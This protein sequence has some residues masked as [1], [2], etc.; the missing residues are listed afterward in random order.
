M[1]VK[2]NYKGHDRGAQAVLLDELAIALADDGFSSMPTDMSSKDGEKADV[3][4]GLLIAGLAVQGTGALI[5]A[6]T[7]YFNRR[8]SYTVT[9]K[10]GNATFTAG[11]LSQKEM[12]KMLTESNSSDD[13]EVDI[14]EKK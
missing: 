6:L 5:N 1:D 4:T 7:F 9:L 13:L 10:R 3:A 2:I 12:M 8:T 14:T 11:N